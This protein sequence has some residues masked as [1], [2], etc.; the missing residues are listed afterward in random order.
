MKEYVLQDVNSAGEVISKKLFKD[1][2]PVAEMIGTRNFTIPLAE[3][4]I[5]YNAPHT[6]VILNKKDVEEET[7][8]AEFSGKS[9]DAITS[10]CVMGLIK[11]QKG[12][13]KE[14]GL[15]G[16]FHEDLLAIVINRLEHFQSSEFACEENAKA[17]EY[18]KLA[19]EALGSR[20]KRRDQA[21]VLGTNNV[22]ITAEGSE[23]L[24]TFDYV[25]PK[26]E[27]TKSINRAT[28]KYHLFYNPDSMKIYSFMSYIGGTHLV[29]EAIRDPK[30]VITIENKEYEIGYF[31]RHDL[32]GTNF[33]LE[34]DYIIFKDDNIMGEA[35]IKLNQDELI[36]DFIKEVKIS[37]EK[38]KEEEEKNTESKGYHYL[39]NKS[40]GKIYA[41]ISDD[42]DDNIILKLI[43]NDNER[44]VIKGKTYETQY[45]DRFELADTNYPV[46]GTYWI[47]TNEDIIESELNFQCTTQ[48]NS[49]K[50]M[51][52]VKILETKTLELDKDTKVDKVP[53]IP[54]V[55]YNL[56]STTEMVSEKSD[57]TA[58]E[59]SVK[60]AEISDYFTLK[61]KIYKELV[62]YNEGDKTIRLVQIAGP[63]FEPETL[64]V[65]VRAFDIEFLGQSDI[66]N[67]HPFI[68][69]YA[70]LTE[71]DV[72]YNESEE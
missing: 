55:S 22:D 4:E 19:I 13:F 57:S 49:E 47:F 31:N 46:Q 3:T 68:G 43:G 40:T 54:I 24:I 63:G 41:Y 10:N 66:D 33:P 1:Y 15:N 39:Y 30:D 7:V 37:K 42:Y 20:T 67:E 62:P 60:V 26:K 5:A 61:D 53:F 51:D 48:D 9:V 50:V 72:V 12:P 44:I 32:V 27:L 25:R 64:E 71:S 52:A 70:K 11:F 21:G 18:L 38:S 28:G 58:E 69:Y 34:G 65:K 16:I 29:L 56:T 59:P 35:E 2:S 36:K 45:F 6:Y 17:I 23:N 14:V 8:A